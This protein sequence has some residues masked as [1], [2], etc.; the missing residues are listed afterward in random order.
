VD[1]STTEL[2]GWAVDNVVRVT[3]T[4]FWWALTSS[5][6]SGVPRLG[7]DTVD[8]GVGD[9]NGVVSTGTGTSLRT[10]ESGTDSL[11]PG[12][13]GADMSLRWRE[14]TL[15]PPSFCSLMEPYGDVHGDADPGVNF[16][17]KLLDEGLPASLLTNGFG[18]PS[19]RLKC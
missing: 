5:W 15:T 4:T 1:R 14:A 17:V 3:V 13:L 6:Q 12:S 9:P 16:K 7:T 10:G 8:V 18:S 2:R 19:Q 11:S